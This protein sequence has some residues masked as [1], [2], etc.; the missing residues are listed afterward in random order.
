M[1]LASLD[2]RVGLGSDIS[3]GRHFAEPWAEIRSGLG[4]QWVEM[5]QV[6]VVVGNWGP[7]VRLSAPELRILVDGPSFPEAWAEFVS[8][9]RA[10]PDS[11]W[12]SFDVGY[13]RAE[14]ISAGLDAPEDEVW[15]EP[16]DED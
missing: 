4:D 16:V 11:A 13:T 5:R 10:R 14:E 6:R 2:S 3:R 15:A 9:V 12:L 8:V 1:S 7:R